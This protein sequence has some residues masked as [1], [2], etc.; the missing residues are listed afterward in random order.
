MRIL[1]FN[2]HIWVNS[3]TGICEMNAQIYMY[4]PYKDPYI[5]VLKHTYMRVSQIKLYMPNKN[6]SFDG[7]AVRV[8]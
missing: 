6:V 3:T 7:I 1:L 4:A 2:L 5:R 8:R